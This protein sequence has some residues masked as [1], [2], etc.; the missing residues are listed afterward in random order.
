[1][2]QQRLRQ[3]S[4]P[5]V[6]SS[7]RGPGSASRP[8]CAADTPGSPGAAP[9]TACAASSGWGL[10]FPLEPLCLHPVRSRHTAARS[11]LVGGEWEGDE[12]GACS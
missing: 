9:C 5:R 2:T 1:M 12:Y 8:P 6:R 4:L 10:H 11:S 3:D 7:G